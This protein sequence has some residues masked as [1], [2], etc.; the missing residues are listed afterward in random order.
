M[1]TMMIYF[2]N[3]YIADFFRFIFNHTGK[4]PVLVT[5]HHELGVYI[6]AIRRFTDLPVNTRKPGSL[7]HE[8]NVLMNDSMDEAVEVTFTVK[9]TP[10]QF[11]HFTVSDLLNINE[12]AELYFDI[13]FWRYYLHASKMKVAQ[14]D[15]LDSYVI[16]RKLVSV[17]ADNEM[18]KKREYR[19]EIKNLQKHAKILKNKVDYINNRTKIEVEKYVNE[20][21]IKCV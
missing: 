20:M 13:D 19:E 12:M 16:S 9:R 18:L 4:D 1:D 15:I 14:K 5:R 10:K 6:L 11:I 8:V 21:K 3:S 17:Q 2:K 7:K